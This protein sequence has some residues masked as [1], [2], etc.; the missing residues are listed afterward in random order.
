ME[1]LSDPDALPP[2]AEPEFTL[3]TDVRVTGFVVP[4]VGDHPV[5][6]DDLSV[7]AGA[8]YSIK[9]LTWWEDGNIIDQDD[10]FRAG[11]SYKAMIVLTPADGYSFPGALSEY[12]TFTLNGGT[13]LLSLANCYGVGV[14]CYMQTMSFDMP[15]NVIRD[16][17]V[18]GFV[19]P[20]AGETSQ[21]VSSLSI[22]AGANYYIDSLNW[23]DGSEYL[24]EPFVFQTG[25]TYRAQ[26]SLYPKEGWMF[27]YTS[28][29]NSKYEVFSLNGGEALLDLYNCLSYRDCVIMKTCEFT[30]DSQEQIIKDVQV[31]GFAKPVAGEQAVGPEDLSVPADAQY[32]VD[33]VIWYEDGEVKQLPFAFEGGKEYFARIKVNPNHGYTFPESGTT[34]FDQFDVF[35]LNGGTELLLATSCCAFE[36]GCEMRTI[37]FTPEEAAPAVLIMDVQVNGFVEPVAGEQAVG[38][39]DLSVPA[40]AQYYVDDV[41]WYE[42]GE[43]KQLPFAFEGGKEYF[44]RIMVNPNPGY[45]FPESGTTGF[46]QFDVFT[47]NGGTE[48][49]LATAC[50]AFEDGCEMRTIKFTPEASAPATI[51]KDVQ[52]TGFAEPVA[53]E[54]AV[55]LSDL[56]VPAGAQYYLDSIVWYEDGEVKEQPFAFEGGKEYFAWITVLP[57]PGYA[58]PESGTTGFELFDVFT[59]NEGTDLIFAT[60]SFAAEDG[61]MMRTIK[62][63]PAP[64]VK[65]TIAGSTDISWTK[66]SQNALVITVK[67]DPDD[68]VC[69]D[70]FTG[71]QID[72]KIL[73]NGTDYTAKAGSTVVTLNP[74]CL[75]K[76]SVGTH[77]VT[78]LFDEGQAEGRI[79]I[80]ASSDGSS[81]K[82]K[83]GDESAALWGDLLVLSGS[84][85]ALELFFVKK[86]RFQH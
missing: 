7:P 67:R 38:P 60:A 79:I 72:G 52:V 62:F 28:M 1:D 20:V 26:I 14:Y 5:T 23:Y 54:Q 82:P 35:T 55:G 17:Q 3:I 45:T 65:Y 63:T 36:D 49:L 12:S 46:D 21:D 10:T 77:T 71:V 9:S 53:G 43:V 68:S 78:V 31:T 80:K 76:L 48:L 42:D 25:K 15:G 51:I 39:E 2:V 85:L 41:I 4:A 61:C 32:Y 40:D 75:Q 74:A 84:L 33:D 56:S 64:G 47:L 16:V 50:C 58:F 83:T 81:D 30:L 44:A 70:H 18:Y 29:V 37:K 22:P 57:N 59:L 8:H 6:I 11:Y 27:L 73:T 66:G 86:R 19:E 34:G 24:T 13:S 69:F